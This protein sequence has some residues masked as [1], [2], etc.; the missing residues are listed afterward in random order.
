MS[1]RFVL[2]APEAAHVLVQPAAASAYAMSAGRL[3]ATVALVVGL[4]S[5]SLGGLALTR[6]RRA[7]RSADR[8]NG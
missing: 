8:V 3:G 2:A 7:G 4:I 1:V 5:V 6:S